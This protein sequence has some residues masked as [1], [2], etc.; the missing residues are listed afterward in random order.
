[1]DKIGEGERAAPV[2]D[3]APSTGLFKKPIVFGMSKMKSRSA[4]LKKSALQQGAS[5]FGDDGEDDEYDVEQN[6]GKVDL[7]RKHVNA[8]I[9]KESDKTKRDRSS[10]ITIQK[11]LEE[12]SKI[13]QYDEVYEE[14]SN[15]QRQRDDEEERKR[16]NLSIKK[17]KYIKGMLKMAAKRN[18]ESERRYERKAIAE[19]KEEDEQFTDKE[20]FLTPAYK[21]KMRKLEEAELE[22]NRRDELDKMQDVTK[23][24]G[25]SG[26]YR[27]YLNDYHGEKR[28]KLE[29]PEKSELKAALEEKNREE[30]AAADTTDTQSEVGSEAT[31]PPTP[32]HSVKSAKLRDPSDSPKSGGGFK[33]PFAPA[34]RHDSSSDSSGSDSEDGSDADSTG[35]NVSEGSGSDGEDVDEETKAFN[36]KFGLTSRAHPAA[37]STTMTKMSMR[38]KITAGGA[39]IETEIDWEFQVEKLK[40]IF[41]VRNSEE[42]ITVAKRE[43][44][45]RQAMREAQ[46]GWAKILIS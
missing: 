34:A 28:S 4:P 22:Q 11:A 40:C 21:D 17:P 37:P 38:S 41:K 44:L 35:Q 29:N 2:K 14:V 10:Q 13:M 23:Q 9:K 46:G 3:Q 36:K 8:M 45:Q 5:A 1:M 25:L 6:A 18:L 12:D 32:P 39:G 30:A 20:K 15:A 7:H 24:H 31:I 16:L 42:D 43:Y 19:H 33:V 27:H 26:F